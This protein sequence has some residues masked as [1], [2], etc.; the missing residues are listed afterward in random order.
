MGKRR[1]WLK[2]LLI[3]GINLV[4]WCS[5]VYAYEGSQQMP[6]VQTPENSTT[7]TDDTCEFNDEDR[8]NTAKEAVEALVKAANAL[9]KF[10]NKLNQIWFNENGVCHFMQGTSNAKW[11]KEL[12]QEKLNFTD[13]DKDGALAIDK[14]QWASLQQSG[15]GTKLTVLE[16]V[17]NF[18]DRAEYTDWNTGAMA[19]R[20]QTGVSNLKDIQNF[21]M[22][23]S[24][25]Q[26]YPVDEATSEILEEVFNFKADCT[27]III[28]D[29]ERNFEC[30]QNMIS[31]SAF[32]SNPTEFANKMNSGKAL[33][34]FEECPKQLEE[35]NKLRN[36]ITEP[37]KKA[38]EALIT[39]GENAEVQCTCTSQ[40]TGEQT[41]TTD[42]IKECTAK[43]DDFVEDS[44]NSECPTVA[45]YQAKMGGQHCIVCNLF[46]TILLAVQN[47]AQKS[48]DS[49]ASPLRSLLGIAFGLYIGYI[50]LIAV[51][52]PATQKI[53]QYLTNLT[54]QGFKVAI[55][56]LLLV[57]P[58]TIYDL[59]IGPLI[60]GGI[61]FGIT[62]TGE[63]KA[64][65]QQ[66]GSPY[67]FA[68]HE[69]TYLKAEVLQNAV[70]AAAAFND[71][72]V[73]VPS[74]GRSMICN[75]FVDKIF[76]IFP[77]VKMLVIGLIFY[78]FG[79]LIAFAIG[80][81]MLDCALQLGIVCAMLP[82]FIACW[83]FK[84]T[85]SYTKQGW[86]IFLNTFFNFVIMG[87]VI[88]ASSQIMLQA[89]SSG[90]TQ[91]T[92]VSYL[93]ANNISELTKVLDFGGMQM[94][95][96]VVCCLIAFKLSGEV[97][98]ITNKLS[99]GL[100]INAGAQI[101]STISSTVNKA[102]AGAAAT[103]WSGA[104]GAAGTMAESSG[105]AGGA[106]ALKSSVGNGIRNVGGALG[107]GSR[108]SMGG[109][110]DSAGRGLNKLGNAADKAGLGGVAAAAHTA[111]DAL[112]SVGKGRDESRS[113]DSGD[114]GGDDGGDNEE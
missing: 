102:A 90:L 27:K 51:A 95:M 48:F 57:N 88:T 30:Y 64:K 59:A 55:A 2:L 60:D 81:Y 82:F 49:L 93:D 52:T 38:H 63:D 92:L 41:T 29:D 20:I 43:D 75:S 110:A 14:N 69:D 101:G 11:W 37:R 24:K 62:L 108:A 58:S 56:I 114:D 23:G 68:N 15:S 19:R 89:L 1:Y 83:P 99:G 97:Q 47:I 72:A 35:L 98:N 7:T 80:F 71:A 73:L 77:H 40:V 4:C 96:L 65:I 32:R 76:E 79:L 46:H 50:T 21:V 34:A 113:Q 42:R 22:N 74:I 105:L 8:K 94:V 100:G 3:A 5:L 18:I 87:V 39:L 16:V 36:E 70:G 91:E 106:R 109:I 6:E 78:I 10:N 86:D 61:E 112:E 12:L 28:I 85:R 9:R 13:K 26:D 25:G 53:S 54:T 31:G 17:N 33:D 45:Q 84:L 66:F 111:G 107:V 104:K 44:V 67:T 103:A